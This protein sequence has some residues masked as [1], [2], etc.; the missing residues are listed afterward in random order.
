MHVARARGRYDVI[1]YDASPHPPTEAFQDAES[2]QIEA[3][4]RTCPYIPTTFRD[5]LKVARELGPAHAFLSL[6]ARA[7]SPELGGGAAADDG[8]EPEVELH[9]IHER[10]PSPGFA[11]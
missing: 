11:R 6:Q 1:H 7:G 4:M 9:A 10:S 8:A 2:D 5:L 3:L